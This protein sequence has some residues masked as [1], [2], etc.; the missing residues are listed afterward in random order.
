MVPK[1]SMI[2]ELVRAIGF[3]TRWLVN[4]LPASRSNTWVGQGSRFKNEGSMECVLK[5]DE[6]EGDQMVLDKVKFLC[7][8]ENVCKQYIAE[9][10]S[11]SC[12]FRVSDISRY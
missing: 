10:F 1:K 6:S 3:G 7:K 8:S 4:S 9:L 12:F 11:V 5:L 2:V